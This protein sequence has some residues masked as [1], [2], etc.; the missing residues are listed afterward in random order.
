MDAWART[1]ESSVTLEPPAD[2]TELFTKQS[3]EGGEM[4]KYAGTCNDKLRADGRTVPDSKRPE[5]TRDHARKVIDVIND[6]VVDARHPESVSKSRKMGQ[7]EPTNR[8]AREKARSFRDD[9][10]AAG[11]SCHRQVYVLVILSISGE[12]VAIS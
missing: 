11:F 9:V 5:L 12:V 10:D 7:K 1:F 8:T 4:P 2:R 6:E 3:G